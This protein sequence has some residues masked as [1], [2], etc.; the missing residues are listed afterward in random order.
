MSRRKRN[1]DTPNTEPEPTQNTAPEVSA[2]APTEAPAAAAPEPAEDP[3]Q[4]IP[5]HQVAQPPAPPSSASIDKIMFADEPAEPDELPPITRQE[6]R[7]QSVASG[8]GGSGHYAAIKAMKDRALN[9]RRSDPNN[10][11]AGGHKNVVKIP[12]RSSE[13]DEAVRAKRFR[14][15]GNPPE[16]RAS[17]RTIRLYE[18][19]ELDENNYDI[20]HLRRSGVKLQPIVG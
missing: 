12:T 8:G 2:A 9:V 13:E 14:V 6:I 17:G 3:Y 10:I 11:G 18:G 19:K 1:S 15:V 4:H 16:V 7:E 5:T 20:T